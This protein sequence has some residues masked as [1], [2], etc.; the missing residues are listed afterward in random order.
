MS[1][2]RLL[3]APLPDLLADLEVQL[4]ESGIADESFFG[5]VFRLEERLVLVAPSGCPT[6]EWDV[7]ARGLLG[8]ALGVSLPALPSS[9]AAVEVVS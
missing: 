3:S 2:A 6:D 1:P 9:V 4:V 8:Q 5:A 7:L